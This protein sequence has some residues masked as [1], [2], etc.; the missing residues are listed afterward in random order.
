MWLTAYT[1]DL[2]GDDEQ[3]R[4]DLEEVWQ[5]VRPLYVK[6]HA[7]I[8]YK[9]REA[10]G[11]DRFDED[12]PIPAFLSGNMW[13]QEWQN[14]FSLV[15]PYPDAPDQLALVD[16]ALEEQGYTEVDLF[17]L[18]N[19]FYVGL[20]LR[21]MTICYDTDCEQEDT[22]ENKECH[23]NNPMIYRPDWEVTCHASAWDMYHAAL[24]DYRHVYRNVQNFFACPLID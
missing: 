21:D 17:D 12:A 14:T 3:F 18:S 11:E 20:G 19:D 13:A 9:Y 15:V 5:T 23:Y 2:D 24:D 8:R 1:L 22:P 10:W 16:E 6:L 4:A 7:Y